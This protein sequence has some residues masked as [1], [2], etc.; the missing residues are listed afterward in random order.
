MATTT[1]GPE[2]IEI[3]FGLGNGNIEGSAGFLSKL[4]DLR[5]TFREFVEY[6]DEVLPNG[7]TK[8]GAFLNL[9]IASAW[10]QKALIEEEQNKENN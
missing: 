6:L 10:A 5:S 9:E 1:L 3:R 2:E 7:R 4:D 8:S